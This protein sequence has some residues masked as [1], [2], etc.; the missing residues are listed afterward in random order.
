[1]ARKARPVLS[2]LLAVAAVLCFFASFAPFLLGNY[3]AMAVSGSEYHELM[4]TDRPKS[5]S[6][7]SFGAW[8]I[9]SGQLSHSHIIDL[10]PDSVIAR[11]RV[12]R[13]SSLLN[14]FTYYEAEY[15]LSDGTERVTH[16]SGPVP[17]FTAR[18][19][20]VYG[21]LIIGWPLALVIALTSFKL[22]ATKSGAS[23]DLAK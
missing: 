18:R 4:A 15:V 8:H 14:S 23:T 17:M 7:L 2:T 9:G 10:P 12:G 19:S 1:M 6:S 16:A 13:D 20:A 5:Y 11:H 22:G 21:G 3:I